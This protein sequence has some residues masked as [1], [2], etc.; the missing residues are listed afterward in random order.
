MR[1]LLAH[2]YTENG[3]IE[4][5]LVSG[6]TRQRE[7]HHFFGVL[8]DYFGIWYF[9][10]NF[11]SSI[12]RC[13][14]R[15]PILLNRVF[16]FGRI[17]WHSRKIQSSRS[18]VKISPMQI[19]PFSPVF[20]SAFREIP[21]F[22]LSAVKHSRHKTVGRRYG[23]SLVEMGANHIVCTWNPIQWDKIEVWIEKFVFSIN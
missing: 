21:F 13:W 14:K 2:I 18:L 17:L 8:V 3:K 11:R 16:F 10:F 1:S 15:F 9:F 4:K 12:Q 19:S 20:L 5:M 23:I 22:G 7:Y 6:S